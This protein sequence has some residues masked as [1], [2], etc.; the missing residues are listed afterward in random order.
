VA[1]YLASAAIAAAHRAHNRPNPTTA[2]PAAGVLRILRR[3]R[4]AATAR[5]A[6]RQLTDAEFLRLLN[7]LKRNRS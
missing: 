6:S 4:R 3:R 7:A 5:L 1:L 2:E